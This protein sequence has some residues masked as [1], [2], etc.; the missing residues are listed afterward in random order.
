MKHIFLQIFT[1]HYQLIVNSNFSVLC[2]CELGNKVDTL[3]A[4]SSLMGY[5]T[6]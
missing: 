3:A 5:P 6:Q 2:R 4:K 1:K